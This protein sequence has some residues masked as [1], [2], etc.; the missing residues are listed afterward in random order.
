MILEPSPLDKASAQITRNREMMS[1]EFELNYRV[2]GD[3]LM[4]AVDLENQIANIISLHFN[5]STAPVRSGRRLQFLSVVMGSRNLGFQEKADMLKT[6][7]RQSYPHL[8]KKYSDKHL[9][10]LIRKVIEH[11][12]RLAHGKMILG[13]PHIKGR[14]LDRIILERASGG[15]LIVEEIT[16]EEANKKLLEAKAV[17]DLLFRL[18]ID[19][20]N[21]IGNTTDGGTTS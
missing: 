16:I 4:R 20:I 9:F 18:E 10:S 12:N 8:K 11:R 2:R 1:R 17:F 6:I 14:P 19:L 13:I 7:L 21:E 3:F 5:P 15:R